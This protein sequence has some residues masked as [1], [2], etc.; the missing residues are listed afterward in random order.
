[1]GSEHTGLAGGAIAQLCNLVLTLEGLTSDREHARIAAD[2]TAALEVRQAVDSLPSG[3]GVE[4]SLLAMARLAP[5]LTG[6]HRSLI[7]TMVGDELRAIDAHDP[8]DTKAEPLVC[9]NAKLAPIPMQ[10]GYLETR[11]VHDQLPA[12]ITGLS[13]DP[14]TFTPLVEITHTRSYV[15]IPVVVHNAVVATMH[16]DTYYGGDPDVATRDRAADFVAQFRPSLERA[17]LVDQLTAERRELRRLAARL[18]VEVDEVMQPRF[19]R[20]T[21]AFP[22]RVPAPSG[23]LCGGWATSPS[24]SAR[25]WGWSWRA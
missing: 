13:S 14:D 23:G 3:A 10:H 9:A 4:E 17:H 21:S 2:L 20:G 6:L 7:Y 1:M 19:A 8:R 12:L 25:S 15:V 16:A 24:G 11:V 22:R 5:R 18:T